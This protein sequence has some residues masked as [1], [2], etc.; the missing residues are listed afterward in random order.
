VK[1]LAIDTNDDPSIM[2]ESVILLEEFDVF[3]SG[4]GHLLSNETVY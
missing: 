4:F 1:G 3:V 2:E